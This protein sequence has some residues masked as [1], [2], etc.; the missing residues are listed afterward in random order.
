MPKFAH[1]HQHTA[2]KLPSLLQLGNDSSAQGFS[3]RKP[4]MLLPHQQMNGKRMFAWQI[5]SKSPTS[6]FASKHLFLQR[7][8]IVFTLHCNCIECSQQIQ[9]SCMATG[10]PHW[11]QSSSI[12]VVVEHRTWCVWHKWTVCVLGS[13]V[14]YWPFASN[15]FHSVALGCPKHH[16]VH[17]VQ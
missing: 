3:H 9:L 5:S 12:M 14:P 17:M 6:A 7:R 8:C 10:C 4:C 16:T 11:L 15:T 13:P 1:V 2:N